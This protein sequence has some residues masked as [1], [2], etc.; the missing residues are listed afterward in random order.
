MGRGER[1]E[2]ESIEVES[3]G[4][5]ELREGNRG[6]VKEREKRDTSHFVTRS[7]R[8]MTTVNTSQSFRHT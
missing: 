8:H 2:G 5:S 4:E 6:K 1:R 3:G 7:F